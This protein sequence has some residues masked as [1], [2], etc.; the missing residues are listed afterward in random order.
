MIPF[1]LTFLAG[2]STMIGT[3]PIFLKRQSEKILISS[4]GFA[5]G[6]MITI[7]VTDL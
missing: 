7:S 2:F 1:L 4:L 6:V 3:I 5:A